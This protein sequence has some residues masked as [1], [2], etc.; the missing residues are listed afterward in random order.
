MKKTLLLFL[1]CLGI[2]ASMAQSQRARTIQRI[3]P[4][5]LIPQQWGDNGAPTRAIPFI[6]LNTTGGA[7]QTFSRDVL[8]TPIGSSG[9]LFSIL[10]ENQQIVSG[11][12]DLGIIQMIHRLN[13]TELVAGGNIG[14][15]ESSFSL[16]GGVTWD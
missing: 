14:S 12:Q 3:S 9:N 10:V 5:K 7:S 8:K 13:N 16:D 11:N 15:I 6:G 1:L 4:S 2:Y